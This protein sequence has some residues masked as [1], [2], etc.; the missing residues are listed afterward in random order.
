MEKNLQ[1]TAA[2]QS[3][4]IQVLNPFAASK[5]YS[6][7]HIEPSDDLKEFIESHWA[8]HWDL[9][10][11]PPYHLQIASSPYVAITFTPFGNFVTGITTGIY[12]YTISGRGKL[13]GTLFKPGGFFP[14]FK[15]SVSNIT[16]QEF[17]ASAILVGL[18]HLINERV[19]TAATDEEAIKIVESMLRKISH[20]KDS[21]TELIAKIITYAADNPNISVQLL[22]R[23]FHLS[24]R[25]LQ[26]IF[27]TYVGVGYKWISMRQRLQQAMNIATKS[28]NKSN[29]TEVAQALHYTDQSH[30]I[31]DFRRIIGM[32]PANYHKLLK[33]SQ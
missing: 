26:E 7:Q 28:I 20:I 4:P 11:E 27:Q 17:P 32:T 29:W 19:M 18:D 16:D 1:K 22:A 9:N 21:N 14:F 25:R 8:M 33:Q 3:I 10:N 2:F 13:Y 15:K 24:E 23:E 12:S 6:Y 5:K 30:F 31:N